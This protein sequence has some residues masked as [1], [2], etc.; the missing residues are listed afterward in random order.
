MGCCG[1][2]KKHQ[3]VSTTQ[4]VPEGR[5]NLNRLNTEQR[6]SQVKVRPEEVWDQ[7]NPIEPPYP[8]SQ[9]NLDDIIQH[10]QIYNDTV[11]G[12]P[13]EVIDNRQVG[14]YVEVR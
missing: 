9:V 7:I 6:K 8:P 11:Q 4:K 13:G 1:S 2:K 14:Y 3:V 10:D 5:E 12:P